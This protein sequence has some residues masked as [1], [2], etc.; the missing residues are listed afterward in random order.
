M[1]LR[2]N[3]L[4]YHG[5]KADFETINLQK[6]NDYKDFGR[7]F[8]VTTSY[9]QAV[10]WANRKYKKTSTQRTSYLYCYKLTQDI[11]P[12]TS[13]LNIHE[14]LCYDKEWLDFICENRMKICNTSYDLVYDRMADSR[15]PQ[16]PK[17]ISSYWYGAL[18]YEEALE[19]LKW[20][21]NHCDQL[22]FKTHAAI[23]LLSLHA[24]IPLET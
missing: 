19:K 21:R 16:I 22:C 8:Y 2:S 1:I 3:T 23:S 10:K 9:N 15:A 5:S 18:T 4:L 7:G 14:L 11:D 12:A 6:A 20:K 24:K 17:I 13:E